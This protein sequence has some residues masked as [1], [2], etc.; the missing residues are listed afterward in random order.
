[1]P[2]PGPPAGVRALA[3]QVA[4]EAATAGIGRG[5]PYYDTESDDSVRSLPSFQEFHRRFMRLRRVLPLYGSGGLDRLALA[6][7]YGAQQHPS[8]DEAWRRFWAEVNTS[9]WPTWSLGDLFNF[10]SFAD[11]VDF[12]DGLSIQKRSMSTVRAVTGWGQETF[13]RVYD[14]LRG[15]WPP[16]PYVIVASEQLAKDPENVVLAGTGTSWPRIARV[17]LAMRLDR[18]GDIL[19]GTVYSGRREAFPLVGG[20]TSTLLSASPV[21][22]DTYELCP[23]RVLAIEELYLRLAA[24]ESKMASLGGLQTA[25]SR[26][27]STFERSWVGAA[28]RL[29]D[30]TVALEAIVGTLDELAF[31]V[32]F[33]VSGM[34]ERTDASRHH[35]FRRLKSFYDTRSKVLTWSQ[36]EAEAPR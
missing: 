17:L 29:V 10:N 34:L 33:R 19:L 4:S 14:P 18:G 1:M 28:D 27:T 30:D 21:P 36:V 6:W 12:P 16:S 20:I 32:A 23:D 2:A 15:G 8:T 5:V 24:A 31:T 7:A 9:A 26:F 25:L 11:H 3:F 13:L 22:G 35:L